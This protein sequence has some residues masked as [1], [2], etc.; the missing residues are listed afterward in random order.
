MSNR[1]YIRMPPDGAGKA[2][3]AG[4]TL[5]LEY[6][7]GSNTQD[8]YVGGIVVGQS[9]Q[10]V[11]YVTR[12]SPNTVASGFLSIRLE[13]GFE[14]SSF[15]P[16]EVLDIA[17][18]N[19]GLVSVVVV[20]QSSLFTNNTHLVSGDNPFNKQHVDNR[21]AANVRFAEG[22]VQFDAFGSI[23]TTNMTS[24][25]TYMHNY[26]DLPSVYSNIIEGNATGLY[27]GDKG[28]YI[29]RCT[30]DP[31]DRIFRGT[32][33][34]H[35]YHPGSSQFIKM[36][37][38]VGDGGKT[39]VVRRWG[40]YDDNNG[41]FF[42]LYE[43]TLNVVLRRNMGNGVEETRIPQS[44]WNGDR[45]DGSGLSGMVVNPDKNNL[46]WMDLAYLGGGR[47]R[48]GVFAPDGSRLTAHSFNNSNAF[49]YSYMRT[50]TLPVA[51]E[52]FNLAGGA[53]STSEMNIQ[54][55]TVDQEQTLFP[56][57]SFFGASLPSKTITGPDYVHLASFRATEFYKGRINHLVA[58]PDAID[59][60]A[61]DSTT[62]EA[63]S[64]R[65]ALALNP[66]LT[67]PT[68]ANTGDSESGV[69]YSVNP[70]DTLAG[71]SRVIYVGIT[72]PGKTLH[73]EKYFPYSGNEF[74]STDFNGARRHISVFVKPI[75]PSHSVD[76][77]G[78]FTWSE[79][80]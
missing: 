8:I 44:E 40:Y 65:V 32:N 3:S 72:Y 54:A 48:M 34:Y 62:G 43:S 55:A 36:T 31:T 29:L 1:D 58:L 19:G 26:D 75:D 13:E 80:Q 74:I 16:G 70:S 63:R 78:D 9:S 14:T 79:Y 46:W 24:L 25:G 76:I 30:T 42:E 22:S 28:S 61:Q 38:G 17:S 69:E 18:D 59:V 7:S 5:E 47:V 6:S 12:H 71:A 33:K 51:F 27:Y 20:E 73:V 21:G 41:I 60:F 50:A 2:V 45:L 23:Q 57:H 64:V 53:G 68:W 39:N 77:V 10:T 35:Q 37:C 56:I 15:T 67:A 11:G 49:D 4:H 52:Q 66:S